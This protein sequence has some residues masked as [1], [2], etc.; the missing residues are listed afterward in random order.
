MNDSMIKFSRDHFTYIN[1]IFGDLTLRDVI[2]EECP[3]PDGWVL[4][5]EKI[6][7]DDDS[8]H[9]HLRDV[10][11]F[12]WCSIDSELQD[13][14]MHPNDTLCQSY[15]LMKYLG[16]PLPSTLDISVQR[17]MVDMYRLLLKN[18]VIRGQIV[19][20]VC[21]KRG[22]VYV[23]S[24]PL[25]Y[26]GTRVLSKVGVVLCDWEKYGYAYFLSTV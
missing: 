14:V 4:S 15:T 2:Q 5:V 11:G 7:G 6:G 8:Y 12:K 23:Q 9:H 25:A 24:V 22:G 19:D 21:Q 26:R 3:S 10:S 18:P 17:R 13:L 1:Q 16:T 20:A